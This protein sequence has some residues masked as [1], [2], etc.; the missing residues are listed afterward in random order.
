MI[1]NIVN[2]LKIENVKLGAIDSAKVGLL[3]GFLTAISETVCNDANVGLMATESINT[4][5]PTMASLMLG[6]LNNADTKENTAGIVSA[7]IF[8]RIAYYSAKGAFV[9][10]QAPQ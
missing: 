9:I 3:T 6:Y 10:M 8:H 1:E 4:A 7:N 5:V 2:T